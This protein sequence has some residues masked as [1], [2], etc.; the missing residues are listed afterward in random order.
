MGARP[1]R[2]LADYA[3][4]YEHPAYGVVRIASNDAALRWQGLGLDLPI[5][6]RHYD[7]FELGADWS[8]W[9]ENKTVQFHTDREGTSQASPCRW[10]LQ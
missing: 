3:G 6:H 4:E 1:S 2:D 8:I 7:L 9:F 10:N 5:S